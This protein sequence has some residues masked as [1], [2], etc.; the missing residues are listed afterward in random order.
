MKNKTVLITGG[1]GF[2]GHHLVEHLLRKTNWNIVIL[3]KLSYASMGYERLRS[4][5]ALE[6]SRVKV[7]SIDITMPITEGVR[8]EIGNVDVIVHMAAESHVD[9]S[10]INP[11]E[12]FKNNIDG[13]VE[14]LEYAKTLPNLEMFFYFSTDEVY[15][16]APDGVAY[17]EWDRHKPTN[18]YSA[19][20][21]AAEQICIS[22]ENTYK[23]PL[24]SINV[25]N[26]FGARQHVEKYIPMV[27]KK[28]L[29][30][31]KV[32]IHSYPDKKRAGSRFYIHAR[33]IA[34]AV[35]FLLERGEIG[36]KYNVVGEKEVDNLELAQLIAKI[37]GKPLKYEMVDF[38]SDRPG[39]DLRYSLSGEK[40]KSMGW[41]LPVNFEDSMNE[42]VK[43]T[44]ENPEWLETL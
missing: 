3:D 25:M 35:L 26:A 40:M 22:Y 29:N 4:F 31:E 34:A 16:S 12:F 7:F 19:S 5:D 39:H 11:R 8:K 10:I 20:K 43:W 14:M 23:L 44:I 37:V 13:T 30:D 36:E 24:M 33:N 21:S 6:N 42:T 9:N 41:E 17:G 2:I 1:C 38:H 28:V 32:M 27:I 18:P 15:G